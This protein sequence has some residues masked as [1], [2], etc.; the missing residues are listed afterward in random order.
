M[1]K[2]SI[3]ILKSELSKIIGDIG[4]FIVEKQVGVM[5]YTDDDFPTD[6]LGELV[7]RV[8]DIG[9]YDKKMASGI[10]SKLRARL[11]LN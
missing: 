6:K 3:G 1:S 4:G 2:E 11:G 5:G 9:V 7:D 10:R 8:V